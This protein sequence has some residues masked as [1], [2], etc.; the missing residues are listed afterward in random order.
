M[1]YFISFICGTAFFYIHRFFPIFGLFAFLALIVL[2]IITKYK[3]LS[4]TCI[5]LLVLTALSG[6]YYADYSHKPVA[7]FSDMAGKTL[8]IKAV[9]QTE[10]VLLNS[11]QPLFSQVVEIVHTGNPQNSGQDS[12]KHL[13]EL[14]LIG[15]FPLRMERQYIIN[16]RISRDSVSLNPGSN[17]KLVSGYIIDAKEAGYSDR[18][19]F[20]R[21]R[22]K[23]NSYISENFPEESA[24]FLMSITTG[25]RSL[26][27]GQIRKAFN[28][29]GMAHILS[30]SGAH[31]G[32][33]LFMLFTAFKLLIK[34]MP[35]SLLVRI[36]VYLTPSQIAGIMC[37]PFITGYLGISSMSI[38]S[39]RAFIMISLFLFG[40][41]IQ[42]KGFWLNTLLLAAAI[43]TI[44]H[45]DSVTD[46]SFHLSFLA[47]LSIGIVSEK[48][49]SAGEKKAAKGHEAGIAGGFFLCR[50]AIASYFFSVLKISLAATIGTAPLVAYYFHYFSTVSLITNA[51]ITPFIG[52]IILPLSLV[53]SFIFLA[54]GFFPFVGLTEKLTAFM[55]NGVKQIAQ[56]DFV[57]INVPAFPFILIAFFYIGMFLYLFAWHNNMSGKFR[58]VSVIIA[59]TPAIIYGIIKINEYKGIHITYLDVGQGDSAVIRLPDN[60]TLVI[61]TGKKGFQANAFLKYSGIRTVDAVALSHGSSDHADGLR[62]L[63]DNFRI[64]EIWDNGRLIYPEGLFPQIYDR[65]FHRKLQRGDVIEGKGYS[66]LVL[67]PYKEFYTRREKGYE[68]NDSLVLRIQTD[69]NTFLFTGDIEQEAEEDISYLGE[70]IK[71]SVLKVPHHGSRTS[72]SEVFISAV[73]PKVA[74]ISAGRNNIY[75]HPHGETLDMLGNAQI[76]RTDR[77]GAIGIRELSDGSIVIKTWEQFSLKQAKTLDDEFR[78]FKRLCEVW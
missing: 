57:S 54:I 71:S 70:Q 42:R 36:T 30:I 7:S 65:P 14:R 34:A 49:D 12:I 5:L 78:N 67:H 38:P 35:N 25:D 52:F 56:F 59:V 9:P 62:H 53:S 39:I 27:T 76:F 8:E 60:K 48:G 74:V 51:V 13:R 75:G 6:F 69:K 77:D 63:A 44:I 41:L 22:T 19:F 3:K 23:V 1:S 66:I 40:L 15:N 37:I 2:F 50:S 4:F 16:A 32:L 64:N 72:A 33:L 24:A 26:M 46:L 29:T 58:K 43:I 17:T 55:L 28:V 47:V 45:P 61:D 10:A 68:N 20:K 31:F 21:A 18:G 73:S 11:R